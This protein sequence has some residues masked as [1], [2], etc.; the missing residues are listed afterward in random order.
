MELKPEKL[1]NYEG[2]LLY[3]LFA[4]TIGLTI[5]AFCQAQ[6]DVNFISDTLNI[7]ASENKLITDGNSNY[8]YVTRYIPEQLYD[9]N[10]TGYIIER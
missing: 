10:E 7:S 1:K 9:F 5:G 6:A 3:S 8:Y 2:I 4:F